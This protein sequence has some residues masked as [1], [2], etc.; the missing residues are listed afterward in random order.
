MTK[1]KLS[2]GFCQLKFNKIKK[3]FYQFIKIYMIITLPLI[4]L[5]SSF[6]FWMFN[7]N[8]YISQFEVNNVYSGF[9]LTKTEL[10]QKNYELLNYLKHNEGLISDNFYNLSEKEHL[11][12][13]RIIIQ[14][15]INLFIL[16]VIFWCLGGFIIHKDL[17]NV[18]QKGGLLSMVIFVLLLFLLLIFDSAF[19]YFHKIFFQDGTWIFD[20]IVSNMKRM[21]PDIFF[22]NIAKNI[23]L[24]FGGLSFAGFYL[25]K[26]T[27]KSSLKQS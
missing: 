12:D 20:P 23:F 22:F 8:Y 27:T 13:V 11:R 3:I 25:G 24:M 18:L 19:I 9:D 21:Y 10:N 7:Q 14:N 16:L 17:F 6:Y 4:L 26:H 5:F 15:G 2:S 1:W